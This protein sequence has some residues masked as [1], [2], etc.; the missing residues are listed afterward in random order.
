M[1]NYWPKPLPKGLILIVDDDESV[2]RL[3]ERILTDAGFSVL[4]AQDGEGAVKLL[5]PGISLVIADINMPHMGGLE[6]L[7]ILRAGS[8]TVPFLLLSGMTLD[9]NIAMAAHLGEADF[10]P[11]PV[12]PIAL[13]D[14]VEDM[15]GLTGD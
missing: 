10:F 1:N 6:L 12:T 14:K 3:L 4:T 13:L 7:K 2:V 5:Y 15:L 11:K 9:F 8:P